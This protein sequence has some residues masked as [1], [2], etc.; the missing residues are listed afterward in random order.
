MI[1][2]VINDKCNAMIIIVI[3]ILLPSHFKKNFLPF[4]PTLF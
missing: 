1:I 4:H 3:I 2:I